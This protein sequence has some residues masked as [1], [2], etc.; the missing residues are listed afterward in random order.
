MSDEP[1]PEDPEKD[2]L[3]PDE[4]TSVE[5]GS[6]EDL[7]RWVATYRQLY[8]FKEHLLYEIADQMRRVNEQGRAE[9]ENDRKL[10]EEERERVGRRLRHW[11]AELD[12]RS[13][14]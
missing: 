14:P 13:R 4:A 12:K 10:V 6:L 1:P 3:L 5:S 2:R 8:E 9:L 11:E 7:R